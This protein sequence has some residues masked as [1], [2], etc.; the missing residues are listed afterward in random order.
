MLL[1]TR[2][3]HPAFRIV[4]FVCCC[5]LSALTF[6]LF[7]PTGSQARR[8]IPRTQITNASAT[9]DV[10]EQVFVVYRNERGEFKCREATGAERERIINRRT[11]GP[12]RLIYAGA[13][14]GKIKSGL[15]DSAT[16]PTANPELLPSA[17]LRIVL[18]GT[19][20]LEQNQQA[21]NAFI[22]AANRWEAVI[23]NPITVVID[24]DFG[25]TF[26][27]QPY[28]DPNILGQTG[29]SSTTG[30]YSDLRQRLINGASNGTESQL[31][32]ALPPSSVPIDV[33]GVSTSA[34]NA[35]VTFPNARALGIVPDI[36]NPDSLKL[37]EADAGIG[38]NSAFQFD[39]NP[40]D[41]VG[42]NLID[43]D[44]VAT[45]EIGHAL[46]FVSNSGRGVSVITVWDLFRFRPSA[47]SLATFATAPRVMSIGGSQ[48]FF[49]NRP[50]TFATFELALS[51]GGPS[52]GP[53]TGD[54]R[55]SS[56]WQDDDLT[57][58]LAYIGIMD[59]TL[60]DGLRRTLSEN[61]LAALDL[62][63]YSIGGPAIVRPPNDDFANA[64]VLPATETGSTTGSSVNA[65]RQVGE[66]RHVG[67]LGD[68]SIWYF[69]QSPV[70]GQATFDT[71][72]SN[73][74]TTL[75]IYTGS[76]ID[77]LLNVAQNDDI[78]SGQNRASRVQFNVTAGT[79]YRI[80]VDGWNGE[81]GNV[82]LN[83][84]ASGSAPTPTPTPTPSPSPTPT[85]P[86]DLAIQSFVASP[87]P[88]STSQNVNFAVVARN[89]GPG[90][91][92][93]S[94]LTV[95]LPF[96]VSFVSCVPACFT[97]GQQDGGAARLNFATIAPNTTLSFLVTGRVNAANG[98]NLTAI[99]SVHSLD[100]FDPNSAN[101]TA[102]A[103]FRVIDLVPFSAAT[104]ISVNAQGAHVLVLRGGTVWAWG[105]NLYGQLGDGTTTL[106]RNFP[107]QVDDLMSVTDIAAGSSYSMALKSDGTV[108]TWGTNER[109]QLGIGST[110]P[111]LSSRPMKVV[112]LSSVVDIEAGTIHAVA[113]KS[114][115]TVWTWGWNPSGDLGIGTRDFDA[116]PTPVQV[117]GLS[118]IVRIFA[119]DSVTYALKA[120]GT[121]WGW[122]FAFIGK[123]GDGTT[124]QVI[125]SPIELPALKNA[126]EFGSSPGATLAMRPD[127]T[128]LSYGNNFTGRLGRGILDNITL[129][130][131]TQIPDLLAKKVSGGDTHFLVTEPGGTIKA[132]GGNDSG[133]LGLGSADTGPHPTPVLVPNVANV[134]ATGASRTGSFALIGDAATGGTIRA[135]G[136]NFLGVLGTGTDFPSFNPAVIGENLTVARPIF[137]VP[138]GTTVGTQVFI[139]CGTPGAMIHY[140]TNGSDPT[141][142]D[143]VIASGA[144]VLVDH[145]LTLKARAFR[146][147]F[148]TSEVKSAAYTVVAPP[149]LQLL[150][151]DS[152]PALDQAVALDSLLFFR[153]PFP[154]VNLNNLLNQGSDRN[155]RVMVVVTNL[156][157]A[158]GE[159]ANSVIVNL[160][161]GNN[162]TFDVAAEDVRAFANGQFVQIIFRLPNNLAVGTCMIRIKAQAR[163]SNAGSIRIR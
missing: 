37:G 24:V 67:F 38:F 85:P 46:G 86:A 9:R 97:P 31:Y 79:T 151:D 140:T 110:T 153:D 158:P 108:W 45:H 73:F 56:H 155:T 114:D 48:V 25:S 115:G 72:G 61:D 118:N 124:G 132:F 87:N 81:N 71:I 76:A 18:H 21:K 60:D 83:W 88:V 93:N 100:T 27:G 95:I 98:S 75:A 101:D 103:S 159:P 147:G 16:N 149:P 117:P 92:I 22:V 161:D 58:G 78:V 136:G 36:T 107:A 134:F 12:T 35:R 123:L 127:G 59:P 40:D 57:S 65:T 148:N 34:T 26:F 163:T 99:A 20:Q 82:S 145:S 30:P 39:F 131:P 106:S 62:F 80:A 142:S 19:T 68:K 64:I 143:P 104:K 156:Q 119:G 102:G 1:L 49:N 126:F 23:T 128:I 42:N 90:A 113:L 47:A 162:Q 32:N 109:G 10:E 44:S 15:R 77:L 150:L 70:N 4:R 28:P 7:W 141:E 139:A 157:L 125:S 3:S 50:S 53:G 138:E 63:G 43:F 130:I 105:H 91:S 152:G 96:G 154:V 84:T 74:D 129:P 33:D 11:G 17:G 6:V 94:S 133:Q 41:G 69:W 5:L 13:S 122:G 52:P 54:G 66:P 51:T 14:R 111:A 160:I 89:L 29:S 137:S 2:H 144:P 135:W 146:S 55:Q 116:H 121:V 8:E 120:D 112:G